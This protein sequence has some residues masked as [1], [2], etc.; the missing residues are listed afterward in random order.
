MGQ[1]LAERIPLAT[2]GGPLANI[3]KIVKK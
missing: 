2:L 1:S 3:Q